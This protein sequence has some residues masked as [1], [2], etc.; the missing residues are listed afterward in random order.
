M[1]KELVQPHA[2]CKA[3]VDQ[4]VWYSIGRRW[5]EIAQSDGLIRIEYKQTTET[6]QAVK[7]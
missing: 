2:T 1:Q 4:Q 7:Q 6:K 5:I 3:I